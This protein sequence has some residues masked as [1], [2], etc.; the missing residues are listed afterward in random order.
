MPRAPKQHPWLGSVMLLQVF[1]SVE[2]K[3]KPIPKGK[4]GVKDAY[5][6][7]LI[8]Y[9]QKISP[10]CQLSYINQYKVRIS[11]EISKVDKK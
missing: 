3:F 5:S 10:I 1:V 9:L 2:N 11:Y 7:N 6:L 4:V 8:G